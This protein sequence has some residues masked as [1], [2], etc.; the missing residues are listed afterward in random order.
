MLKNR[1]LIK[2]VLSKYKVR[3]SIDDI[4]KRYTEAHR[5]YHN[6]DHINFFI[7]EILKLNLPKDKEDLLILA[8]LFHDIWYIPGDKENEKK[9]AELLKKNSVYS[10]YIQLAYDIIMDTKDHQPRTTLS[11]IFCDIDM[12]PISDTSFEELLDGSKK[13]DKE[14]ELFF[15]KEDIRKGRMKFLYDIINTEYGYKNK[16]N[17]LRLINYYENNMK[18]LESF[19]FFNNKF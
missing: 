14:L 16:E 7:D 9:S 12:M 8:A 17:L 18:F 13:V 2:K 10:D 19:R 15:D 6:T 1:Q 11:K 4:E 5:Y 3:L